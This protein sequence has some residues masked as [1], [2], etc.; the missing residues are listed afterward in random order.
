MT[1]SEI[2]LVAA[3]DQAFR[4]SL[5]F[6]LQSAG[7]QTSS[8]FYAT[9]AFASE[10]AGGAVC[11]VIDEC[12]IEDWKLVPEQF[13]RFTKP[14]IL[15]ASLFQT[16]PSLPGV[17]FVMKPFLGEPLIEAVC[18][19]IAGGVKGSLSRYPYGYD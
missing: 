5:E 17:T 6:A 11:A 7:F 10:R 15:L 4:R 8:H 3:P 2:V 18:N 16:P 13:L 1:A 12:A 14:I 9:A 19:A